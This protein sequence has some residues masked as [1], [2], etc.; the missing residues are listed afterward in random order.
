[1]PQ[2]VSGSQ[3]VSV[4]GKNHPM[5]M[6]Q[7]VAADQASGRRIPCSPVAGG[8]LTHAGIISPLIEVCSNM[9]GRARRMLLQ[10]L[11][12]PGERGQV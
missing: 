3:G 4:L 1:M 10:G 11:G 2:G 12:G 9:A 5:G 6:N 8:R 7:R